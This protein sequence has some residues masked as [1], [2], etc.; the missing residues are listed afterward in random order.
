MKTKEN[1]NPKPKDKNSITNNFIILMFSIIS[2]F[3]E[4]IIIIFNLFKEGIFKKEILSN[5]TD[6]GFDLIIK[7]K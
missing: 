1:N 2:L 6:L 5:K 3:F 7:R 4:S